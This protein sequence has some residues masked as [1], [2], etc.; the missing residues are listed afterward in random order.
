[1]PRAKENPV[2][3]SFVKVDAAARRHR[4]THRFKAT[5]QASKL[6]APVKAEERDLFDLWM[7]TIPEECTPLDWLRAWNHGYPSEEDVEIYNMYHE[8][9]NEQIALEGEDD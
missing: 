1:M 9:E 6:M 4:Q 8:D 5:Q 7:E 2:T 3:I